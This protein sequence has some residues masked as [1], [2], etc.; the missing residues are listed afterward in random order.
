EA[1]SARHEA[2][3]GGTGETM[4]DETWKRCSSCKKDIAFASTYYVCSVSTCNRAR[5]AMV[6]CSVDCW[7]QHVPMM[8]HR[9][10]WAVEERAPTRAQWEAR[11]VE[12]PAQAPAQTSPGSRASD[13]PGRRRLVGEGR[14]PG[15]REP[16]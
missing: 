13:R 14:P 6:F 7:D 9:E 4:T 16:L 1:T 8:R 15:P 11:E 5:V 2:Q 3:Q 12:V 10:A